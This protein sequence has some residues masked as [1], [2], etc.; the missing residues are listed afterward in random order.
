MTQVAA[1]GALFI[2]GV[3]YS[4]EPISRDAALP[5]I[6]QVHYARR[7]PNIRNAFGL[8]LNGGL[9]G[10]CTFGIPPSSTLLL[11]VCGVDYA[12]HVI[13]LNRL[14]LLNNIKN[15]ASR[16]VGAS[17]K[18]LGN[19]I[20]V[21]YA[22]TA[23][24]HL[25]VVY[26]ATNAIYTGTSKPFKEIYIVGKEHLHHASHKGKTFEEMK[27][28]HGE[29]SVGFRERSIKHRYVFITGSKQFKRHARKALKYQVLPYPKAQ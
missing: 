16:L 24:D 5:L 21:S 4:V 1:Q 13:E 26:Q 18:M 11:G 12:V 25:G 2:S 3:G 22:D 17:L 19:K 14:C 23:Q 29:D 10:V 15:E 7:Q 9:V 28:I 20:V 6:L 27:A 8:Y